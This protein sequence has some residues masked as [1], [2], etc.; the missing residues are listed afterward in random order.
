MKVLSVTIKRLAGSA[1]HDKRQI[2]LSVL[3]D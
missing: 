2:L 3:L 1:A